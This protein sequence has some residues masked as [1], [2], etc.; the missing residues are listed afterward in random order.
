M[1]RD[2]LE[3][4]LSESEESSPSDEPSSLDASSPISLQSRIRKHL[5]FFRIKFKKVNKIILC[6][7]TRTSDLR[8]LIGKFHYL[9]MSYIVLYNL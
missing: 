5:N 6:T 1:D 3:L 7:R 8:S 2:D 9:V 4:L